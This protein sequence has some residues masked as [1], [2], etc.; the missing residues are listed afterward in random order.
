MGMLRPYKKLFLPRSVHPG[1]EFLFWG[2]PVRVCIPGV[3]SRLVRALCLRPDQ[4]SVH[5]VGS[6]GQRERKG[7][8]GRAEGLTHISLGQ[9]PRDKNK[10]PKGQRPGT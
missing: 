9:R 2:M 4:G 3:G 10:N 7:H 5:P 8:R 6:G 1:G